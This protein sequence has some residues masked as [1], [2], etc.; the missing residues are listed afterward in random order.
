MTVDELASLDRAV[1]SDEFA[2][3]T[4]FGVARDVQQLVAERDIL[5]YLPMPGGVIRLAES[6]RVSDLVR[7]IA[8][9]LRSGATPDVSSAVELSA[10]LRAAL[11]TVGLRVT[12][13]TDEAFRAA[14]RALP[15]TRIRWIAAD[16]ATA[17]AGV[18]AF[19]EATDG[20][21]D[22][23]I[24]AHPVTE[25][26]RVEM[27]PFLREQAVAITAHRFGTPDRLSN[28]LI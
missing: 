7:V 28:T 24:V 19:A 13:A 9:A 20:R 16:R 11:T 22:L 23:A 21:P 8:A 6:G 5:R 14:G 27:L 12:V 1:A 25:A 15:A 26:G 18:R 2:W 10:A 17:A 3:Q 4:E